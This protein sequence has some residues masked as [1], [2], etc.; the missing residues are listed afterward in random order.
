MN[1]SRVLVATSNPNK[2]KELHDMLGPAG[3]QVTAPEAV[4]WD[5]AVEEDG[6]TL[7]E[8]ALKKARAGARATG[9]P[10]LADD[11]GLFVDA[12]GGGPGVLSARYAGP[13]QDASANC[14]KLLDALREVP[15]EA[16]GAEFRCAIALV[17]PGG[18]E[19]VF[20]GVCRGR[21]AF[22]RHGTAGF[23]YDPL[24]RPQGSPNTF[25]EMPAGEKHGQSHRGRALRA[26]L[27]FLTAATDKDSA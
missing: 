24:F 1:L 19:R 16:R 25:A 17:E 21:I 14:D 18:A 22:Q 12:L 9:M 13:E 26:L 2:I 27:E 20:E 8:N 10:T 6:E 7:A 11:S 5:E 4:G 23:G 3:I 15:E